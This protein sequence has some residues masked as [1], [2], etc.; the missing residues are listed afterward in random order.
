[1][2]P[3][4]S[5]H[6]EDLLAAHLSRW[7]GAWPPRRALDLRG[8]AVR[9]QPG[10]DGRVRPLLGAGS[11]DGVLVA[12]PPDRLEALEHHVRS[13]P[14]GRPGREHVSVLLDDPQVGRLLG[15]PDSAVGS[16]VLRW[17]TE[18]ADADTLPDAGIWVARHD[19]RVPSWLRPFNGGVLLAVDR[20]GAYVAGVGVKAH[21]EV[22]RELAVVTEP[23]A[24]GRGL[25]QRLV[26]QAARRM[27]AE[28]HVVTYLH[29]RDNAAS[30]RVAD[31]VGFP[32][33]GWSVY[34]LFSTDDD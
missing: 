31:A 10:W 27:L 14:D 9:R 30:A 5:P 32:D 15:R 4:P 8:A 23:A 19:P 33:R 16:G 6:G 11:P 24:R 21:D 20:D 29:G 1:M 34:A 12:V 22:G 28:G 25:A 3:T 13:Q 2:T 7:I 18:V 17:T 26:A